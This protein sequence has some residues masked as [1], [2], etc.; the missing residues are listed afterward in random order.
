MENDAVLKGL[1]GF[2]LRDRVRE[3]AG[4]RLLIVSVKARRRARC[5]VKQEQE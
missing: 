3:R 2:V 4:H 5:R 1:E